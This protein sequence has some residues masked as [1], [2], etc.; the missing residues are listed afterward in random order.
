MNSVTF[1]RIFLILRWALFTSV[2]F[3]DVLGWVI[4]A[5]S[6]TGGISKGYAKNWCGELL[7]GSVLRLSHTY[8]AMHRVWRNGGKY[9]I[10]SGD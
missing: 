8:G 10:I 6:I 1:G 7:R 9:G 3:P 5:F 2:L 4:N